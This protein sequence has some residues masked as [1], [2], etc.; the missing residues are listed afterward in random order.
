MKETK[1][2][3]WDRDKNNMLDPG[4]LSLDGNGLQSYFN[5]AEAVWYH[6]DTDIILMQYIGLKDKNGVEIY[7]GDILKCN[8]WISLNGTAEVKFADGRFYLDYYHNQDNFPEDFVEKFYKFDIIG[9]VHANP[10]LLK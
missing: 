9:N 10:E 7:E 2:R 1:F 4:Y 8:L 5:E 3:A 6:N